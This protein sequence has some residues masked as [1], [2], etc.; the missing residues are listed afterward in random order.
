[1]PPGVAADCAWACD[2]AVV[3]V[4]REIKV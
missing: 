2:C 3:V 1:V 4:E